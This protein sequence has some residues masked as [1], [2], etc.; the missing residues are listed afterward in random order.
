MLG[1]LAY[2]LAGAKPALFS[3]PPLNGAVAGCRSDGDRQHR[4]DRAGRAGQRRLRRDDRAGGLWRRIDGG[5]VPAAAPAGAAVRGDGGFVLPIRCNS[6][7]R[8]VIR[9]LRQRHPMAWLVA[10]QT[11]RNGSLPAR[12]AGPCDF[13]VETRTI[14]GGRYPRHDFTAV[15]GRGI[16]RTPNAHDSLPV[17]QSFKVIPRG[18]CPIAPA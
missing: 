9:H 10:G 8:Y 17:Y 13:Q 14:C 16:H 7:L 18:L 5:G 6:R 1:L 11:M 15:L 12:V 3:G 4:R 2:D